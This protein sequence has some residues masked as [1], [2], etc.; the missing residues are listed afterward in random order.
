M[1]GKTCHMQQ[2]EEC[3]ICDC[4]CDCE[5]T[6]EFEMAKFVPE[7]DQGETQMEQWMKASMAT[8]HFQ[9]TASE[10]QTGWGAY[11]AVCEGSGC[12]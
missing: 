7:K 5:S 2:D 1:T 12:R 8:K 3:L 4:D 11:M 9:P 6:G 10:G